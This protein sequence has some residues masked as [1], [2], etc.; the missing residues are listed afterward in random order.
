MDLYLNRTCLH[1]DLSGAIYF[2]GEDTLIVADLHFAKGARYAAQGVLLPPYDT[3]RT[4]QNLSAAI[5]RY[6][7][8]RVVCLGDSF[9][10]RTGI[11]RLSLSDR[12]TLQ[13]TMDGIDW[14]W[15]AGNHDPSPAALPGGR[16]ETQIA[17][18]GVSLRHEADPTCRS[19]E[20]SGHFHPKARITVRG[21]RQTRRCFATDGKRLILPA[22]GAY[23]GGLDVLDPAISGLFR[24]GFDALVLGDARLHRIPASRL[25]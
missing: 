13:R 24:N 20:I 12:D 18:G 10:D 2:P 3:R 7:A 17:V 1:A 23:A 16:V 15:I 22:F 8:R 14:I 21:R 11:E 5:C 9:D 6:R 4:V 19:A 25:G